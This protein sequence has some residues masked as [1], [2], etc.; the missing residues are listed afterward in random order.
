MIAD[1]DTVA[2]Q[3]TNA[4]L[5]DGT[6]IP[7]GKTSPPGLRRR[8][9]PRHFRGSFP[10]IGR[11]K[12]KTAGHHHPTHRSHSPRRQVH[13]MRRQSRL[14]PIPPHHPLDGRRTHQPGQP[15][16]IVQQMPPQSTRRPMASS[17]S[18]H[19][20]ILPPPAQK[21]PAPQ[22]NTPHPPATP[23]DQT[24]K[25]T[26]PLNTDASPTAYVAKNDPLATPP[27]MGP[28][29]PPP[30]QK[31]SRP[32]KP[33]RKTSAWKLIIRPGWR[34]FRTERKLVA[35]NSMVEPQADYNPQQ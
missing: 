29:P 24:K 4:R 27:L 22:Q 19:R 2:A 11:G 33:K 8:G 3:L 25:M 31:N 12:S 9:A 10:T 6:P 20:Q 1:Y 17:K 21:P 14:V 35:T 18:T 26:T 16:P 7:A 28:P 13:R 34:P 15:V 32:S 30:F 5:A 23:P